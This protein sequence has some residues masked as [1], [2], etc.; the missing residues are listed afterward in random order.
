LIKN[1]TKVKLD[2]PKMEEHP[3]WPRM[4]SRY[5]EFVYTNA[6]KVLTVQQK[7]LPQNLVTF[8]EDSNSWI[9]FI[10]NLIEAEDD[11]VLPQDKNYEWFKENKDLLA[12]TY[13]NS[14]VVIFNQM[15]VGT[16]P[17]FDDAYQNVHGK[18]T[19]FIIQFTGEEEPAVFQNL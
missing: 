13:P 15:V 18:L 3:D 17:T 7:E 4:S 2:I 5:K 10:G 16:Y 19:G 1:G 11:G 6:D 9:F 14:H 12:A 8:E